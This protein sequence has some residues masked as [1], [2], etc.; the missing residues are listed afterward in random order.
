MILVLR[1]SNDDFVISDWVILNEVSV[2]FFYRVV[3]LGMFLVLEF[4]YIC[5]YVIN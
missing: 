3:C 5:S 4:K 2:Y 1:I